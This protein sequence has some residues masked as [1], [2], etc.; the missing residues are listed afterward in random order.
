M[1]FSSTQLLN[2]CSNCAKQGNNWLFST[3]K[4]KKIGRGFSQSE[5]IRWEKG[6]EE[7]SKWAQGGEGSEKQQGT[8]QGTERVKPQTLTNFVEFWIDAFKGCVMNAANNGALTGI[9]Y[10]WEVAWKMQIHSN[11]RF[12]S[13]DKAKSIK[14]NKEIFMFSNTECDPRQLIHHQFSIKFKRL[15]SKYLPMWE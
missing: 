9:F 11:F 10:H 2:M 15:F 6:W 4:E 14:W 5:L 3:K 7:K 8:E 13:S 1:A 12:H